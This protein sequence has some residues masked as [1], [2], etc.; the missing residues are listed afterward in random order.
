MNKEN[1]LK[2]LV[3]VQKFLCG[4]GELEGF[5]FGEYPDEHLP[6]K[7]KRRFWW[8]KYLR[9]AVKDV[10]RAI[11]EAPQGAKVDVEAL[12]WSVSLSIAPNGNHTELTGAEML[13]ISKTV[14]CIT[15]RYDLVK[16]RE[17]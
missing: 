17:G 12:K 7:Y 1:A 9:Q 2:A 5:R 13:I 8:R 16:K 15:T 10:E 6:V 4:E 3:T 14:E 11:T